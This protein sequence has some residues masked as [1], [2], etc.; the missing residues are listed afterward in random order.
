MHSFS[1]IKQK[2]CNSPK[3]NKYMATNE[4]EILVISR[5]QLKE[6]VREILFE[7]EKEQQF[8]RI[9]SYDETC[10]LLNISRL[11][12]RYLIKKGKLKRHMRGQISG[13]SI[14]HFIQQLENK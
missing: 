11:Q 9:Y 12:L 5:T 13:M 1:L 6:V 14:Y 10:R 4:Q 3:K 7:R 2:L 8:N